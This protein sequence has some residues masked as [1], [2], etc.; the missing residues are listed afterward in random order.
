MK[1]FLDDKRVVEMS[2]N[3]NKGLGE[4]NDFVILRDDKSF[5]DFINQNFDKI[6]LISFD[7]DLACFNDGSEFTGKTAC[8]FVI[9]KCLDTGRKFPDWYVHS[10]NNVGREN[11]IGTILNYVKRFDGVD[12]SDFR[13]FHKGYVNGKFV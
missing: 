5:I 1:V 11:I 12:I 8:E 6:E 7:H 3:P 4:I 10:D 13:Y 9:E 2:H